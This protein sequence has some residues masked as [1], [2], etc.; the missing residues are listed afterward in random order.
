MQSSSSA[1][2]KP[3]S[4]V[5]KAAPIVNTAL[6]APGN[7][8]P[9]TG[10]LVVSLLAMVIVQMFRAGHSESINA[11]A[12]EVLI[13]STFPWIAYVF[14]RRR[15][16]TGS[17]WLFTKSVVFGFQSGAILLGLLV[18]LWNVATRQFGYGTAT[19]IIALVTVQ[20]VGWYLAVFSRVPGFEKTSSIL[21]G[22]LVFFVCCMAND[23]KIFLVASFFS[24][25][26][27][28]WLL[29]HYW[30]RLDAKAIDGDS[31][32]LKL[33][34]S[35]VSLTMLL[36]T[37]V[38]CLAAMIPFSP[39]R[40]YV[41]GFMPFSGGED[42]GMDEFAISGIGDGNMLAAG[43]NAT[44][45]GAVD[46]DQF[47]EGDK[48]SLYD[49]TSERYEGPIMKKR[50]SK[51][52][53][54]TGIAKHAHDAKRSEQSGRTFRTMRHTSQETNAKLK[55]RITKALFF[56]E[57]S[58]PARFSIN[59]FYQ[60]DGWDWSSILSESEASSLES[61]KTPKFTLKDQDG[62]PVFEINRKIASYLTGQ[63]MH[64]IK[65]MRLDSAAIPAPALLHRWHIPLVNRLDMFV[66]SKKKLIEMDVESIPSYTIIDLQSLVPN[67]HLLR[68]D[69]DLQP[70][71]PPSASMEPELLQVPETQSKL[72]IQS[73]ANEWIAGIEP[74]WAQV[75]AIVDHLRNDF[76]L[77]P[78]WETDEEAEDSVNLFL[79]QGGGPS[80]MFATTCAMA[81]RSAG[82]S[83]RIASG[84]LVQKHDFNSRARQSVVAADNLHMWPEVCLDGEFWIP[85]EPTPGYP[86][87]YSTQTTWQWITANALMLYY[88]VLG[89]P[90]SVL[91]FIGSVA[92]TV[93]MR[94]ELITSLMLGWW[95]FVR[96]FW[97]QRLL[98]T[99]RQ[100]IDLR[101]WFAGDGR[102]ASQ[103]ISTWYTRVESSALDAF[104][105][106]WNAKN[107]SGKPT[108]GTDQELAIT[109][110]SA[111]SSLSLKRIRDFRKDTQTNSSTIDF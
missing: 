21:S 89:N 10:V 87:P 15:F 69:S 6:D 79:N 106:F 18:I 25:V 9:R 24:F 65:I 13:F 96:A 37:L 84:F 39:D 109:C 58:V 91:L 34:G 104:F 77:N 76:D 14:L 38:A 11:L 99:T 107:Y 22:A 81:L 36:L 4:S 68:D 73:L 75:E 62:A 108:L 49:L 30:S 105:K 57:G 31:R 29:G 17:Q 3:V 110:R 23:W 63:R 2:S 46:S 27:L 72:A 56:V 88:W 55:D 42:G 5:V 59:N 94:A 67:Y 95:F 80:Y 70:V 26:G 85:V 32:S 20:N 102:P 54:L 1:N 78:S 66:W 44:T 12:V 97:P 83:T 61:A 28:W 93:L 74:G 40:S 53:A 45:T 71:Q 19:E 47:I 48:P 16:N 90:I 50:R 82:Y 111:I 92:L 43:T 60:F 41:N 8:A 103:T 86:I 7:L 35:A 51:A 101:F 98:K 64:R 100:L 33:H 52:M